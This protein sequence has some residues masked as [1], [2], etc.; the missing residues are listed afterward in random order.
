[1]A[2]KDLTMPLFVFGYVE[3]LHNSPVAQQ[4]AMLS[5][6][7]HLMDFASRFKWTAIRAFHSCVLKDIK[8]GITNWHSDFTRFQTGI[9]LPSQELVTPT[10]ASTRRSGNN[11]KKIDL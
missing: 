3:C 7:S 10:M 5:H 8:Q 4:A 11:R 2:H 6:L 9:L 1:M